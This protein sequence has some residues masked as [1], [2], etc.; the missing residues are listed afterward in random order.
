VVI[1]K[2]VHCMDILHGGSGN[3]NIKKMTYVLVALCFAYSGGSALAVVVLEDHF[4]DP[5]GPMVS[6]VDTL[7]TP[8]TATW[9][10]SSAGNANYDGT[11]TLE[12]DQWIGSGGI[13]W[14][15]NLETRGVG[16]TVSG[17]FTNCTGGDSSFGYNGDASGTFTS[18]TG[19]NYSFGR[20]GDAIGTF[21]NCT[22]G[23]DSFGAGGTAS[24]GKFYF[25]SGGSSSFTTTGSPTTGYCLVNGVPYP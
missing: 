19:G 21:N 25:C 20:S 12:I 18:C 5:A 17:T 8:G 6:L 23:T 15:P 24:G 16:G 22:G 3:M 7:P 4:T 13:P 10:L 14:Q 1:N 2:D 9:Y 11:S